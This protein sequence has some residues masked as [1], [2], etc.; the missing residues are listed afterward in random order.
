[1]YRDFPAGT[2]TDDLLR[3]AEAFANLGVSTLVTGAVGP[4]PA[5][6]LESTFGPAIERLHAIEPARL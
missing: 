3:G 6:W 4:D 1:M 2:T 5:A